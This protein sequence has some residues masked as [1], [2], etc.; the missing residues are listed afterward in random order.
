VGEQK[1]GL[2]YLK[3]LFSFATQIYHSP[4]NPIIMLETWSFFKNPF[5]SPTHGSVRKAVR[6]ARFHDSALDANKADPPILEMYNYFHPFFVALLAAFNK[7]EGQGGTQE[8]ATALVNLLIKELSSKKIKAWDVAIQTVY[9]QGSPQYIDLL[10]NRR[11]PF[12]NG[13]NGER[14]A[15]VGGLSENLEGI[16]ALASV[17]TSVDA[18]YT[19]LDTA[20]TKQQSELSNTEGISDAFELARVAMC[21]AQYV[22][23][24]KLMAQNVDNPTAAEKYFDLDAIRNTKQTMFTGT[25]QVA[26][27][28]TIAERTLKPTDELVLENTGTVNIM[29]YLSNVKNGQQVGNSFQIVPN[30]KL[31]IYA[32]Q[33]GDLTNNHF[34]VVK[35][36]SYEAKGAYKLE[37][38]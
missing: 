5:L 7:I 18:F 35:N 4:I 10:P 37:I 15:A 38:V 33:F 24:G 36:L 29:Y 14:L 11:I 27:T 32:S 23:L 6:I 26:Q 8:G 13:T 9:E 2:V 12:Q 21:K 28:K 22:S 31:V 25:L 3:R 19:Q 1:G 30:D 17:K 16:V 20:L 34:L